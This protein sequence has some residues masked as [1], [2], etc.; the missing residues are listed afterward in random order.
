MKTVTLNADESGQLWTE[1]IEQWKRMCSGE[2]CQ[3]CQGGGGAQLN[4]PHT[5]KIG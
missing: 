1:N 2:A 3:I 4:F 5:R